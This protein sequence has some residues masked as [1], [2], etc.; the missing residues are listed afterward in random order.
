M[1]LSHIN[2]LVLK[3]NEKSNILKEYL[4]LSLQETF[5]KSGNKN[6][7]ELKFDYAIKKPSSLKT[8]FE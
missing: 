4:F 3:L 7:K 5:Y 1:R 2:L 8:A 6:Y